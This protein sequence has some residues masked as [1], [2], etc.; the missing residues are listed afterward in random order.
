MDREAVIMLLSRS[1]EGNLIQILPM[2]MEGFAE[3]DGWYEE[4]RSRSIMSEKWFET[5]RDHRA[6]LIFS[7]RRHQY[8]LDWQW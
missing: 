3:V 8:P 7:T 6:L 4:R 2:E 1:A 5:S